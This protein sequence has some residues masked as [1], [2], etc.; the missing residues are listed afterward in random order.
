MKFKEWL[1]KMEKIKNQEKKVPDGVRDL[2]QDLSRDYKGHLKRNGTVEPWKIIKP[3]Q[4]PEL[5]KF[6]SQG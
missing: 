2:R 1:E 4:N 6:Y 3:H 5:P